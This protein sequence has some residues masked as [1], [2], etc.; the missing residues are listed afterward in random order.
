[1]E[2]GEHAS[3]LDPALIAAYRG[4]HYRVHADPGYALRIGE[5]HAALAAQLRAF[6]AQAALFITAWNPRGEEHSRADN[7]ARHARLTRAL[8]Q[9]GWRWV[10]GF[11]AHAVDLAL[12]EVSVLVF[13]VDHASAC[14]LGRAFDQNSVVWAGADAVPHLVLLR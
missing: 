11:G 9:K 10:G 3:V 6:E 12:G 4:T 1:M 14:A 8:D 5:G 7:D 2:I 13:G